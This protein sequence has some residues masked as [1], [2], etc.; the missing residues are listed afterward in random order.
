MILTFGAQLLG[1]RSAPATPGQFFYN[2][3][4]EGNTGIPAQLEAVPLQKQRQ[5]RPVPKKHCQKVVVTM[6]VHVAMQTVVT[7]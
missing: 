3:R 7:V 4:K 1:E 5:H 2:A 6:R